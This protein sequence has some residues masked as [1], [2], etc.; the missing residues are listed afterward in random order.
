MR[1]LIEFVTVWFMFLLLASP[2]LAASLTVSWADNSVNEDGFKIERKLA[3][4]GNFAEMGTVIK[5]VTTYLDETVPDDQVYCY[6]LRAFNI[7]GDSDYSNER[8][9]PRPGAPG[10][11]TVTIQITISMP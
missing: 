1:R 4:G 9:G 5:N 7:A 11:V 2:A 8:C 3:A 10:N 6:R